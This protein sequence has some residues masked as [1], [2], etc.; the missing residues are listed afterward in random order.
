MLWYRQY[1][2]PEIAASKYIRSIFSPTF[3]TSSRALDISWQK[4]LK[5][6]SEPLLQELLITTRSCWFG[7]ECG[8]I[9]REG[10]EHQSELRGGYNRSFQE[11]SARKIEVIKDTKA[12][13]S[14][15][16]Q[17]GG[18]SELLSCLFLLCTSRL[19]HPHTDLNHAVSSFYLISSPD[20]TFW[21]PQESL[22]RLG[23]SNEI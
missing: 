17:P 6:E 3:H 8:E 14:Q 4:Q 22:R 9:W 23:I 20:G 16:P 21:C 2:C 18:L 1:C 15:H 5:C 12:G 7:G 19:G 13:T 11:M 10:W